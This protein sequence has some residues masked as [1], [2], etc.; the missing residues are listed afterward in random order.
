MLA[1]KPGR[2]ETDARDDGDH[3]RHRGI[4]LHESEYFAGMFQ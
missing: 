2:L 1:E 4:I 3:I